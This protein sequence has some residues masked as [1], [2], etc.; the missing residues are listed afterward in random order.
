MPLSNA[1]NNPFL[2]IFYVIALS[3]QRLAHFLNARA[4]S[5]DAFLIE[6]GNLHKQYVMFKLKK[7]IYIINSEIF[8]KRNRLFLSQ[9]LHLSEMQL[10]YFQHFAQPIRKEKRVAPQ[11]RETTL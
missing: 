1:F 10:F 9:F 2:K 5:K 6:L 8:I 11:S 7:I 4:S 3:N